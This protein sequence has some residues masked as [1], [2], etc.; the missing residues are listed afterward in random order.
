MWANDAFE[1][2][3]YLVEAIAGIVYT[4]LFANG[5]P[6]TIP[7]KVNLFYSVEDDPKQRAKKGAAPPGGK[8]TEPVPILPNTLGTPI[9]TSI[10][11]AVQLLVQQPPDSQAASE[12]QPAA[13]KQPPAA[14]GKTPPAPLERVTVWNEPALEGMAWQTAVMEQGRFAYLSLHAA[15]PAPLPEDRLLRALLAMTQLEDGSLRLKLLLLEVIANG[16]M[17]LQL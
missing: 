5:R 10:T 1:G 4:G 17:C 16:G 14:A 2:E 9:S 11:L 6:T 15:P 13:A 7:S 3:G 8:N 12:A